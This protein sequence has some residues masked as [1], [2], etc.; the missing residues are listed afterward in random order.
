MKEADARKMVREYLC[1]RIEIEACSGIQDGVFNFDPDN[2][3]LFRF[4]LFDQP[5]TGSSEY[6]TISKTNGTVK[7][8]GFHGE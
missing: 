4:S 5:S 3:L 7:Y 1:K 8:I 2:E 6:V